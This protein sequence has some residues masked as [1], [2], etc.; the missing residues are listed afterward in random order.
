MMI[1]S[2]RVVAVESDGLW[3]ETIRKSTCGACAVQKGCGHGIINRLSDGSRNYLRVLPGDH[4]LSECSVDDQVRFA[5]PEAVILR[6]SLV[7][8]VLPL[9]CMLFGFY[10]M[11]TVGL[12]TT[13]LGFV[14]SFLPVGIGMGIFQSPN[15]SAV[16][17]SVPRQRL[18]VTSGLLSITRTLGQT[19]GIAVVGALWASRTLFH[20]G[21]AV[22]EGATGAPAGAQVAGSSQSKT[23]ALDRDAAR[24]DRPDERSRCVTRRPVLPVAPMTRKVSLLR[25]VVVM[26]PVSG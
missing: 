23:V 18:G 2:G 15:N 26:V 13:T 24:T 21:F 7:V 9:L 6:G 5:V 11:S 25:C 8:Y 10:T 4:S 12:E 14:L 17:G 16:M 20:H 1:E 22:P 3:V 19:M